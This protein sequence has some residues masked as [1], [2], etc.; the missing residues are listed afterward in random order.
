LGDPGII[1]R[2]EEER[3]EWKER[4]PI[5]SFRER[6]LKENIFTRNEVVLFENKAKEMIE[7]ALEFAINISF[8]EKEEAYEDIFMN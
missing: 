5:K 4:C 6:L 8:P 2:S 1:Y 7:E 3:K